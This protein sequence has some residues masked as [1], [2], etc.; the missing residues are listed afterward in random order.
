MPSANAGGKNSPGEWGTKILLN[1]KI[2]TDYLIPV[3]RPDLVIIN[4]KKVNLLYCGLYCPGD[5]QTENQR[6]KKET[7][8]W[9]LPGT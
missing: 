8:I 4:K 7:N 5:T 3:R 2:Q 6:K 1:Y 9:T